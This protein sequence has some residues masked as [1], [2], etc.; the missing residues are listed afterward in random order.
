M[1]SKIYILTLTLNKSKLTWAC[2]RLRSLVEDETLRAGE[3][4]EDPVGTVPLA[5]VI[6]A[7]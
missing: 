7:T 5:L 6:P 3:H 1:F 4:R 2:A